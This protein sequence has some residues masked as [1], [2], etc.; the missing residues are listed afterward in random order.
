MTR[1]RYHHR[2]AHHAK[3]WL[4][5][6]GFIGALSALAFGAYSHAD[7]GVAAAQTRTL[8]AR[9][10]D[11]DYV[12]TLTAAGTYTAGKEG[13][14]T[15]KVVPKAPYKLNTGFAFKFVLA[16]PPAEHV[17]FTKKKLEKAD[18]TASESAITFSVPFTPGKAGK[19]S[20]G[21]KL[22]F[23]TVSNE[24]GPDKKNNYNIEMSLTVDVGAAA[25]APAP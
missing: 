8:E 4:V 9:A 18:A 2:L 16:D 15:L 24:K 19:I 5:R 21:G 25:P 22:H 14:L 3:T 17:T 20:V 12:I 7:P 10:E 11:T 23:Q 13:T 6:C 1:D